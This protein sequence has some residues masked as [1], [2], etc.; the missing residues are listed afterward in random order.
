MAKDLSKQLI[1]ILRLK[2]SLD[3]IKDGII[4]SDAFEN[5][6]FMNKS[7]K[8]ILFL[9]NYKQDIKKLNELDNFIDSNFEKQEN[10]SFTSFSIDKNGE[11]LTYLIEKENFIYQRWKNTRFSTLFF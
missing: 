8:D 9:E 1:E 2:T 4:I 6:L 5:I 10:N 3:Y 11:N 7:I